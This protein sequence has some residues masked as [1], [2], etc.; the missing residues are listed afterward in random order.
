MIN[1]GGTDGFF[2]GGF[3]DYDRDPSDIS[4]ITIASQNFGEPAPLDDGLVILCLL[5]LG[6]LA[7][8]KR[9]VSILLCSL[10]LFSCHHKLIELPETTGN[11]GRV[12]VTFNTRSSKTGITPT[13]VVTFTENDVLHVFA[14]GIN[15]TPG[16]YLG[17]LTNGSDTGSSVQFTGTIDPW[18]EGE[19]VSFY[20]LGQNVVNKDGIT[21]IDFSDQSYD[22]QVLSINGDL[23]N[24][25]RN[26]HIS[27]F[28]FTAS[29]NTETTSISGQLKNMMALAV[30]NTSE[31][32]DDSNVKIIGLNNLVRIYPDGSIEYGVAG[33]NSDPSVDN[34]AGHII[35]G[36]GTNKK[37]VALLPESE[38]EAANVNVI[39]TSNEKVSNSALNLQI[40]INSFLYESNQVTS[41][42]G[43]DISTVDCSSSLYI[44]YPS[45]ESCISETHLFTVAVENGTQKQVVFSQGNLVYDQGRFKQH[46]YPWGMC[47]INSNSDI[48]V[49]S[50]FDRFGWGASGYTFGQP[51]YQPYSNS[52]T[53]YSSSVGYGYGPLGAG[54]LKYKQSF[55]PHEKYRKQDW[56]WY[57]FGMDL[58]NEYPISSENNSYWRTL[59]QGE[60]IYLFNSRE[61][62]STELIDY[63]TSLEIDN[64]RF[65]KATI[66]NVRGVLIFPDIYIHP[67][68]NIHL[69]YINSNS[70]NGFTANNISP[71]DFW[72]L[73]D[74]G[75][76]F[77]PINSYF[78]KTVG[79]INT[80]TSAGYY[81]SC[82][83]QTVD[84]AIYCKINVTDGV[85][86][87][88]LD[89]YQ[90]LFVRLV[91]QVDGLVY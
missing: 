30:F 44:N 40:G 73:H 34:Q 76:E 28:K 36:R 32:T 57:Q 81:W 53:Q 65:A 55:H 61:T 27:R 83:T 78:D 50:T 17:H 58:Y 46:R 1:G 68:S 9:K 56:G 75:V 16:R 37:Y 82:K 86:T 24:I 18:Y 89:R 59:G 19:Q 8:K 85:I 10:F 79:H 45:P 33:V 31:F 7:I 20:Y 64:A 29:D 66:D 63:S 72:T 77:L 22:D 43:Y 48:N 90:G 5:G 54:S 71:E 6:Y 52:T 51:I 39:F 14:S 80:S 35:I 42:T 84:K 87:N 91:F 3:D 26:F 60:W 25:S 2:Q 15:E 70:G 21:L 49:G 74:A 23:F 12:T 88:T 4:T 67:D 62:S 69:S 11:N 41:V 47:Q 13:G 38:T